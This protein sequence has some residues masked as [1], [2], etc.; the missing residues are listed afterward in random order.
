M[1]GEPGASES[2]ALTW[3]H[4]ILDDEHQPAQ[5]EGPVFVIDTSRTYL[6]R[7]GKQSGAVRIL[8]KREQGDPVLIRSF[9]FEQGEDVSFSLPRTV[10]DGSSSRLRLG[11]RSVVCLYVYDSD[12]A[13]KAKWVIN[14]R[15]NPGGE[16]QWLSDRQC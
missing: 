13:E 8:L 6:F 15:V 3:P 10:L 4:A 14:F 1:A 7:A 5:R 12:I 11:P 9:A 2:G 16:A